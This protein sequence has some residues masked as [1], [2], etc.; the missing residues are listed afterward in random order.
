MSLPSLPERNPWIGRFRV[1]QYQR[2]PELEIITPA[3]RI[4]LAEGLLFVRHAFGEDHLAAV[5]HLRWA[6]G[7][8]PLGW[9]L[10]ELPQLVLSDSQLEAEFAFVRESSEGTANHV[11]GA[12]AGVVV[13]VA[14]TP[15]LRDYCQRDKTRI[16]ARA[17][18]PVYWIINLVDRRIGVY[19]QPSGPTAA[20]SYAAAVAYQPGDDVPL[21]LDGHAAASVPVADLLP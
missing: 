10:R 1:G 6:I 17:G 15:P 4:E 3:D 11:A 12:D 21:V 9:Q 7:T 18:V 13:D 5:D 20:P 16:Y 14:S 2:L 19:T 8:L